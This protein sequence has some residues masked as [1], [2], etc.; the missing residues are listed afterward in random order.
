MRNV[1]GFSTTR[2]TRHAVTRTRNTPNPP[3]VP[4]KNSPMLIIVLTLAGMLLVAA[5]LVAEGP[6]D[7]SHLTP[8]EQEQP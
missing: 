6:P 2:R 8:I 1:P 3:P 4:S 7:Y 5:Q